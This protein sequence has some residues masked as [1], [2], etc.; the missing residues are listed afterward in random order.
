[1]GANDRLRD[2]A[3]QRLMDAVNL[4]ASREL[5]Y[6]NLQT[7]DED[8][9]AAAITA[10]VMTGLEHAVLMGPRPDV[11]F[12][13]PYEPPLG[14]AEVERAGLEKLERDWPY[15]PPKEKQ[16]AGL[17]RAVREPEPERAGL[18]WEG[19]PDEDGDRVRVNTNSRRAVVTCAG[20]DRS[21]AAVVEAAEVPAMARALYAAAG[22]PWPGDEVE[23]LRAE[24]AERRERVLEMSAAARQWR[25]DASDADARAARACDEARAQADVLQA[26]L[27]TVAAERDRLRERVKELESAGCMPEVMA[28]VEA[29]EEP[30]TV[31]WDA[32]LATR[33][34]DL[35]N[36][37][38][39]GKRCG[40][41]PATVEVLK[42][43]HECMSDTPR[44]RTAVIRW[45][46]ASSPDLPREGGE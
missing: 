20:D 13:D 27:E 35:V 39:S 7:V 36:A 40:L 14:G 8:C 34:R 38:R 2:A 10:A 45:R 17:D 9:I 28:V 42:A 46:E 30:A 19:K 32:R 11:E 41:H 37:V 6:S 15:V 16:A 12:S 22:L 33:A 31:G 5:A 18:P 21:K 25:Q 3:R 4:A 24:V 26:A 23:R 29:F 1:M 44:V 43:V